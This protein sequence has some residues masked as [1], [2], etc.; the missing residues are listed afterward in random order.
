[1]AFASRLRM[2]QGWCKLCGCVADRLQLCAYTREAYLPACAAFSAV[3][4]FNQLARSPQRPAG[5]Q[6]LGQWLDF[7]RLTGEHR[8]EVA[9][10]TRELP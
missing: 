7:L 6:K 4:L 9:K 10:K 1:M 8:K 3:R 5:E 2:E